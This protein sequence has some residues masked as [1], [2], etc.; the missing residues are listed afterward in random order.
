VRTGR[1]RRRWGGREEK[2]EDDIEVKNIAHI[3][4]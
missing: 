1:R 3:Y 2:T 4:T